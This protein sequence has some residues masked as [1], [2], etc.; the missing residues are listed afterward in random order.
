MTAIDYS[1]F[2]ALAELFGVDA[3]QHA[4]RAYAACKTRPDL[5]WFPGKGDW[6]RHQKAV[7]ATCPVVD[8]CLAHAM[9]VGEKD[10]IWGGKSA[11]ERRNMRSAQLSTPARIVALLADEG[12]AFHGSCR[13]MGSML[14]VSRQA[15]ADH[16]G[17]LEAQGR[18]I[19]EP[20]APRTPGTRI[21]TITL[22]GSNR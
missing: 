17:T 3:Q 12:G 19:V 13:D 11:V 8:A 2:A 20:P 6:G 9:K 14:G 1:P 4:W 15:V 10:G 22:N 16:V 5:D 18:I 7:C 21:R